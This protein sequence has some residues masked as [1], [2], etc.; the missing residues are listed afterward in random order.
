MAAA[1]APFPAPRHPE[2]EIIAGL[3]AST[4]IWAGTMVA[5]NAAGNAIPAADTASTRVVGRAAATV[6]N[7]AG[8]AGD[9]S[10]VIER[11]AFKY[12]NSA[13]NPVTIASIGLVCYVSDDNT[14]AVA[15][16]PTND[17]KAGIVLRVDSDGVVVDLASAPLV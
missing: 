12:N 11:G 7:S 15:A 3:A 6:D 16:G 5:L 17:I 4:K 1:T 2:N 9:L 8:S 13:A 10:I 14:V